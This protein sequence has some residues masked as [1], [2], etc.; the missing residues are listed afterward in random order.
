LIV[1]MASGWSAT[2]TVGASPGGGSIRGVRPVSNERGRRRWGRRWRV[3]VPRA[4]V[5]QA[6]ATSMSGA[7][8]VR[9]A[10]AG[11]R[12]SE[13][14]GDTGGYTDE[15]MRMSRIQTEI[16]VTGR[17]PVTHHYRFAKAPTINCNP[18][19]CI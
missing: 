19:F 9:P 3:D 10:R 2:V 4:G 1:A 18:F 14:A 7:G 17:T 11:T 13:R 6:G 5:V 12:N 8:K 15:W 16:G